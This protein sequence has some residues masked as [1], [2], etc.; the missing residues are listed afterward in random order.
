LQYSKCTVFILYCGR[1]EADFDTIEINLVGSLLY[2]IKDSSH[3]ADM[4]V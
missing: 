2:R 3:Q 1:I 4:L